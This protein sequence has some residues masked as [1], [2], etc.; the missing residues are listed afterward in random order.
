VSLQK[1]RYGRKE[2]KPNNC[3]CLVT[4]VALCF[5]L[6]VVFVLLLLLLLQPC[7]GAC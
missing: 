3:F 1:D 4:C 7:W 5:V 6:S 2:M